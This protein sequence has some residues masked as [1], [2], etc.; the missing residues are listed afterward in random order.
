MAKTP[1]SLQGKRALVT[2][3][4]SGIGKATSLALAEAGA[5]VA[6]LGRTRASVEKTLEEI[7]G[8]AAGHL[9]LE[10]D[11]GDDAAMRA[12]FAI[13]QKTWGRLDAVVANA[14]I[15]GT[16]APLESLTVDEWNETLRVNLTGTFLTVKYSVPLLRAAGGGA[17]AV[18]SSVNGTRMFSNTGTAA[19]ACSKAAQVAF[20]KMTA[21]ELAK[22]RVRINAVCPGSI[23]TNI[24]DSTEKRDLDNI[25]LPVEYPRG[26]VPLTGGGSGTAGQVAEVIAFLVS[27]ASG[28]VSGAEIFVDGAQSLLVG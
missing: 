26:Q 21:L 13:L 11:T 4:G 19:Y 10:A 3:G 25:R 20:V 17:V 14:G 18:V 2:G 5:K 15:N 23:E 24:D 22:D 1:G 12:A 8:E 9:A 7:G 27:D 16:W 6:V 28:H